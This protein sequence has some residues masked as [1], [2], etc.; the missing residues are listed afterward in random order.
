MRSRISEKESLKKALRDAY[1][2]KEREGVGK[3]FRT[4][5]MRRIRRIGPLSAN[6]GF[7][8]AFEH[9]TWRLVPVTCLLV[10]VLTAALVTMDFDQPH[11]YL[12]TVTADLEK[13]TTLTQL[14]DLEG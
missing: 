5:V 11:D 4:D 6:V 10:L 9:L 1:F 3:E 14:F 2:A 8:P 12:G 7:W 13:P